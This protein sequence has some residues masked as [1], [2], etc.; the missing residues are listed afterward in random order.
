M[1]PAIWFDKRHTWPHP[2]KNSSLDASFSRWLSLCK[3]SKILIDSFQRYWWSKN[4]AIWLDQR[5]TWPNQTK[6]GSGRHFLPLMTNDYL[7]AKLR[8]HLALSPNIDDQRILQTDWTRGTT[9][10]TQPKVLVSGPTF[11]IK[12]LLRSSFMIKE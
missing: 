6:S 1:N 2:N 10:H 4:S 12:Y 9:G 3:K 11:L 8:Y 7:H 5:Y